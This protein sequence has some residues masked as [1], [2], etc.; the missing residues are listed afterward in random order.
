MRASGEVSLGAAILEVMRGKNST[1]LT[2]VK[3]QRERR[4]TGEPCIHRGTVI[5]VAQGGAGVNWVRGNADRSARGDGSSVWVNPSFARA[6]R[7]KGTSNARASETCVGRRA[8]GVHQGHPD[9][10]SGGVRV[11]PDL[12]RMLAFRACVCPLATSVP[13][14]AM[15]GLGFESP[16][17][18]RLT[19]FLNTPHAVAG[20][21]DAERRVS[22]A[23]AARE[24]KFHPAR[25]TAARVTMLQATGRPHRPRRVSFGVEQ[26]RPCRTSA[27][28]R[29][30]VLVRAAVS[31]SR[32]LPYLAARGRQAIATP[33]VAASV[34]RS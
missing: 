8:R 10:E 9:R 1:V 32:S 19:L 16:G 2:G 3:D 6:E 14:F 23:P 28:A 5:A 20:D 18:L 25:T 13:S 22:V 30:P 31:S 29:W 34:S 12:V 7:R 21:H 26:T 11:H 17:G 4:A 27:P 24:E 15:K 33:P